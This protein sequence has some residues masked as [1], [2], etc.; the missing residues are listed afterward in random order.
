MSVNLF[1]VTTNTCIACSLYFILQYHRASYF[2][3]LS[4]L[5][6]GGGLY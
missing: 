1:L 4:N 3:C 6:V 2:L 5:S